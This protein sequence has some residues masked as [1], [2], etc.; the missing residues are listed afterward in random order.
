[1]DILKNEEVLKFLKS[2]GE[3]KSI[4]EIPREASTRIYFRIE[5]ESF[6]G[7]LC[8][9]DKF[10]TEDY[11]FLLVQKFLSLNG[12]QVPEILQ[13]DTHLNLILQTDVGE[14]D[15]SLLN[16]VEYEKRLKESI[17]LIVNLQNLSP[18][19]IIKSKSFDFAKLSFE[20]N[21][22][23]TAYERLGDTLKVEK[24]IPLEIKNFVENCSNE[25][26]K[27]PQKVICHR[28][29]H[30][31]NIMIQSNGSLA[32]IDFQDMMM[33][34]PTYDLVSILYDAYKPLPLAIR[35]KYYTY[36]KELT[37]YKT[38]AFREYY[39]LQA[40]QRSF[41]ALGTYFV[42]FHDKGYRKY[43]PSIPICLNNLLEIVQLGRFPDSLYLFLSDLKKRWED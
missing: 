40:F 26:A 12:F 32:W 15:L 29:Y 36:F 35:E 19:P 24:E 31:R 41:K 20:S 11:P 9:D 37:P 13:F 18:I 22:T 2:Q 21:H 3:V 28:D 43:K 30:A 6:R 39:L 27:F 5:Y 23:Y 4:Y 1:M 7:I 16:D 33:G 10:T 25:L 8:I 34:T 38:G 42:M 14:N 17:D